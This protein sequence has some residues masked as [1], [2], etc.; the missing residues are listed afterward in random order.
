[1]QHLQPSVGHGLEVIRSVA[2]VMAVIQFHRLIPVVDPAEGIEAII[3]R[4]LGRKLPIWLGSFGG[5]IE[6][7]GELL[8]GDV[9]IIIIPSEEEGSVVIGSEILESCKRFPQRGSDEQHHS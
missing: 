7:G 8:V 4:G 3:T 6:S 1:M 9:I 5:D 2:V